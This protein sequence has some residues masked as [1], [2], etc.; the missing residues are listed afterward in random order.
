MENQNHQDKP[1]RA[2]DSESGSVRSGRYG[3]D[4]KLLRQLKNRHIA[5]IRFAFP[6]ALVNVY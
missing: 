5:M 6:A 3:G 2:V 1:G 4:N